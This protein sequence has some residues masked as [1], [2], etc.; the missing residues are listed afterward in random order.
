ML[1]IICA[2]SQL[3][4]CL[5]INRINVDQAILIPLII[6]LLCHLF[7]VLTSSNFTLANFA[8]L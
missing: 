4:R 3:S 8:V 6:Y 7:L 2:F 1:F 5:T